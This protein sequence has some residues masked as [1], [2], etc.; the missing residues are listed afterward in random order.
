MLLI[1]MVIASIT[2]N[3]IA[4]SRFF[5]LNSKVS[6]NLRLTRE[7]LDRCRAYEQMLKRKAES[8]NV[9]WERI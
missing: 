6:E 5:Y 3:L 1:I 2:V 9:E 8:L 4:A 7:N